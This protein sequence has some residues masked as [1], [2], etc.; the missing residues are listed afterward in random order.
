MAII[1]MPSFALEAL[2]KAIESLSEA[3]Q[4][5]LPSLAKLARVVA[6]TI[7]RLRCDA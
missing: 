2:L 7:C 3:T 5:K 4:V 1:A 6:A